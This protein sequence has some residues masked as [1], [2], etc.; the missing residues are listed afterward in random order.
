VTCLWARY[1]D[2]QALLDKF[3]ASKEFAVR[4]RAFALCVLV[5]A[6]WS[7]RRRRPR[8]RCDADETDPALL[9]SAA[10]C[11]SRACALQELWAFILRLNSAVKD[12]KGSSASLSSPGAA[13]LVAVLGEMEGWV[14]DIPAEANEVGRFGNKA[15][16]VWHKRL[17]SESTALMARVVGR[18]GL[19]SVTA[20]EGDDSGDALDSHVP[21]ELGAYLDTSFGNETRIDYGSG[22]E[23]HFCL[24][25]HLLERLR[26][27]GEADYPGV[28]LVVFPAYLRVARLLQD[29]YRLEPA[30][31]HGVWG[32]DDFSFL[33]FVWGSA[34][35]VGSSR[36]LPTVIDDD[37][38]LDELR[39]EYLYLDAIKVIKE[40]KTGPFHEH[41]P[42]LYDVSRVSAGW[43]KIN[44][45]MIKMYKGEVWLKVPVIQA[46]LFGKLFPYSAGGAP[47]GVHKT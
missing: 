21:E 14:A 27:F 30:G 39:G 41:S 22:H 36:V 28:V 8:V 37:G 4:A 20:A 44:Q 2:N 12:M 43:P 5:A 34:Q 33:P 35:L 16:R 9:V 13:E 45:G 31:S 42:V 7:T 15:Y 25:L 40:A 17:A 18:A 47:V 10:P 26:V 23:A 32:L 19:S 46:F 1:I 29:T 24:M 6:F 11:P 3:I 38:R